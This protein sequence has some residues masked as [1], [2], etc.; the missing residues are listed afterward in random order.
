MLCYKD[1]IHRCD[2]RLPCSEGTRPVETRGQII[3]GNP[4]KSRPSLPFATTTL[5]IVLIGTILPFSP[6]AEMLG[7]VPLPLTYFL[8]L[9]GATLTYLALVELVKRR[10]MTRIVA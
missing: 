10:L 7:F 8:F 9:A 5:L 4:L 3:C 6:V 2:R 1:P